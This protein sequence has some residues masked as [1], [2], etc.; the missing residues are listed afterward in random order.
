MQLQKQKGLSI[1]DSGFIIPGKT[2]INPQELGDPSALGQ[3]VDTGYFGS[4][5]YFAT[6]AGYPVDA[7]SKGGVVLLTWVSTRMPLPTLKEDKGLE[8]KGA[9]E[10]FDA[11]FIPVKRI[12]NSLSQYG[13][14]SPNELPDSDE[15]VV[16]QK[17]QTL[18]RFLVHLQPPLDPSNIQEPV[19]KKTLID[20]IF[21]TLQSPLL[22]EDGE[23][24]GALRG[25]LSYL[26]VSDKDNHLTK[27]DS[28]FIHFLPQLFQQ[29]KTIDKLARRRLRTSPIFH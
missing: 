13:A 8:G 14:C 11:H 25:K 21:Q 3:P 20:L 7:Y 28:P 17:G 19:N 16:F 22:K 15:L 18:V 26:L 1:C 9:Y 5:I 4:G 6:G 27:M 10:L 12:G 23:L 29:D 24:L 2:T